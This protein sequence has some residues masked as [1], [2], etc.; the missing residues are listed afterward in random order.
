MREL[1]FFVTCFNKALYVGVRVWVMC[2]VAPVPSPP[3]S[4]YKY[5]WCRNSSNSNIFCGNYQ[6]LPALVFMMQVFF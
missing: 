2:H 5:K 3:L 1:A 4:S 6:Y